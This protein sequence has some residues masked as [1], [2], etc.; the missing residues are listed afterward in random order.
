MDRAEAIERFE[1]QLTAAQVVL[2]SGFGTNPG[3]NNRLYVVRKE[4]AAIALEALREQELE[5]NSHDVTRSR[6]WISVKDRLP[7]N[8]RNVL[9][10]Y[11]FDND[12]SGELGM[13][14]MGT[15][16]YF[17]CD[18]EPH[19]QHASTGLVVTHWMPMPEP[20]EE[21]DQGK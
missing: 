9:A 15:L 10:Y 11:G 1:K 7:E 4:M 19:W 8:E 12:G 2:D 6:E 18:P 3:E 20:P 16:S 5:R 21:G 17:C 13:M 14:F